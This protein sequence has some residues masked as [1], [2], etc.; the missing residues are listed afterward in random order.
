[1]IVV[2]S[3]SNEALS[4][5]E[6]PLK[7]GSEMVVARRP[8]TNLFDMS[9]RSGRKHSVSRR[10]LHSCFARQQWFAGGIQVVWDANKVGSRI[11]ISEY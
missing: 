3:T 4:I 11:V 10:N 7:L 2:G 1:M 9:L 8:Q 6:T 5:C